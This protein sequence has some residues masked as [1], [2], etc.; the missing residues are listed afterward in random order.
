[1]A[2]VQSLS[3]LLGL[4]E[5]EL[6]RR[7]KEIIR[8]TRDGLPVGS[9]FI[10]STSSFPNMITARK[11]HWFEGVFALYN[12]NLIRRRFE[13][14]RVAGLDHLRR[15]ETNTPQLLYANHSSWWDGLVMFQLARECKLDLYAMMEEKQLRRYPFH[16]KLGAFSVVR[17]R[18]REALESIEY[19]AN[20]LRHSSRTLLIF[21]Q[22]ETAPND[23]RPLKFYNGAARI[24][25]RVG[26]ID[27]VPVALR[28]EF[29]DEFRPQIF[30]RVGA[31][32]HIEVT[33]D[34]NVKQLTNRM[35]DTL[36]HTLDS[37]RADVIARDFWEY[38]EI[39][40]WY[41]LLSRSH[42]AIKT[43]FITRKKA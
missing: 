19:A 36:T 6:Q 18:P 35:A 43:D 8:E 20:L 30:A 41:R 38:E 24:I 1:M 29:L 32:E 14:L 37:V 3:F 27:V 26:E 10:V 21:P 16:R 12:R 23:T 4:K 39:V 7:K 25:E 40:A 42:G 5:G 22:G 28:Y 13:G 33:K 34:F 15:H 9:K 2:S 31:A 11:E 17:A